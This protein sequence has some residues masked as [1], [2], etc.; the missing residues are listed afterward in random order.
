[1]N[2]KAVCCFLIF[3]G[4]AVN[5]QTINLRGKVTNSG[6][7]P[8]A[9]AVVTLARQALKDTTSTDGSYSISS[10]AV[11]SPKALL[12][13][14][15]DIFLEDGNLR[16]SLP[17]PSQVRIEI[18]DI[19]GD[20]LKREMI[21]NASG[22]FYSF[23]IDRNFHS[24]LLIIRTSIGIDEFTFR[25]FPSKGIYSVTRSNVASSSSGG[26]LAKVEAIDDTLKVT[27]ANYTN[28]SVAIISYD[29]EVNITLDTVGKVVGHS[30][31]CGKTPT[32]TSGTH[33]IQSGGQ[34][35]NYTIR[36]PANY[37]NSHPYPLVFAYHWVGGT[38][39]DVD[40]GGSSGYTWS[41]YGLREKADT[42]KDKQMIFVAPQGIG[43]G[44]GNGNNSDVNFTDDMIKLVENDLCVDTTRIF[45]MGFSY[46]GG[47]TK[48]LG[49][50]RPKVF[51]AIAVYSGADFLSG[52]CDA[53]T[54][55]PIAY[56]GLHSVS[57]GTN[58]YSSGEAIRDRFL[59]NNGC[60]PQVAAKP[61]GLTH[62]ITT[63]KGCKDGYPTVW[64]AF[65]GGG[66]TP[67]PVDGSASGMGG[68]DKTWT[69]AV[70]WEFFTQF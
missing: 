37:N 70:V 31:G 24:N 43:N 17:D 11:V 9:N 35:R 36:I 34:T 69:K 26:K 52:G 40:G 29:Q 32:L 12:P 16:F 2:K 53:T 19:K 44:W 66:H 55:S 21:P 58:P 45:A 63:Y 10:T 39:G 47:M 4:L 51:R 59:K 8:I 15:Q 64:C 30:P 14:Q 42:S 46:G 33:T 67:A 54:T 57:D 23:N 3:A 41:Y 38:M 68:G 62:V 25:Y 7:K 5:A 1:M 28:K 48:A 22:G 13:H 60:T 49:C 61:V 6:G 50:Q 20:L 27:A 56:I 65:D 18:F